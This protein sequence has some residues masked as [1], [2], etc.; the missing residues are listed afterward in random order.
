MKSV[1]EAMSIGRSFNESIQK[2]FNSLEY[3]LSGFDKPKLSSNDK[4][5]IKSF[6]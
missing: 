4:K 5:T 6:N 2:V 1:G 3:G